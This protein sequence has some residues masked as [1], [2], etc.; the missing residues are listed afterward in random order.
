MSR[1]IVLTVLLLVLALLLLQAGCDKEKIVESTEYVRDIEYIELP[2]DTVYRVDTVRDSSSDSVTIYDTVTVTDTINQADTVT[3]VD[4]IFETNYVYDTVTVIDTV[5]TIQYHYDTTVVTDTVLTVRCD[6]NAFTAMAAMQYYSDPL[7]IQFI[8][9]EFG[10]SD[11][12]IFYLSSFQLEVTQVS[13]NVYDLYGYI[14]YWTPDWS[15]YYPLEYLWRMTFVGDDPGDPNDW[16]MA[17]SPS[18]APSQQPGLKL[19]PEAE[20]PGRT[21]Y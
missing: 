13:A 9:Q 4:T 3:L 2:G 16:Q 8:N 19:I 18:A 15:G 14:D 5:E 11:G 7:V 10:Y 17:E 6:P 21:L 1:A 12:W 20:Q